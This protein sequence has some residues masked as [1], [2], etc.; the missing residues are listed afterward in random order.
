MAAIVAKSDLLGRILRAISHAVSGRADEPNVRPPA[1]REIS[2]DKP[3]EWLVHIRND[4]W[5]F[6]P[7]EKAFTAELIVPDL[8]ERVRARIERMQAH[9]AQNP[10]G[11]N[12]KSQKSVELSRLKN[13]AQR[14][15]TEA[16]GEISIG[17]A[18]LP[19]DFNGDLFAGR[20]SAVHCLA[21]G[22]SSLPENTIVAPF[23]DNEGMQY[24]GQQ[25]QC[26]CGTIVAHKIEGQRRP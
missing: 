4:S 1:P 25:R 20:F 7:L 22:Q 23:S 15:N 11:N 10:G 3:V 18:E 13:F 6:S 8:E 9:F 16:R 21:C 5:N 14:L 19:I 2:Q 24:Y 26:A 17:P 12:G